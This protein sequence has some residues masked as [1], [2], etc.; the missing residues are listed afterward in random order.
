MQDLD[1]EW[2]NAKALKNICSITNLHIDMVLGP[3]I[4][5]TDKESSVESSKK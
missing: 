1:R 4:P 3:I 2:H 5:K